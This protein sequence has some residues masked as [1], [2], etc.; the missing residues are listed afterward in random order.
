MSFF[1]RSELAATASPDRQQTEFIL[2]NI[3]RVK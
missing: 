2:G 3:N 1:G